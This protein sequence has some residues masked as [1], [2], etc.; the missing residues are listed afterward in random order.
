MTEILVW[1]E[2]INLVRWLLDRALSIR[3]GT[4]L[5]IVFDGNRS[6]Y[7]QAGHIQLWNPGLEPIDIDG[8]LYRVGVRNLTRKTVDDARVS[9]VGLDPQPLDILPLTLHRKDD[10]PQLA[11]QPYQEI[12]SVHP[13]GQEPDVFVDVLLKATSQRAMQIEHIA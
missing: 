3:R 6:P 9:L 12:F 11:G 4:K 5:D 1:L 2:G 7:L 10:N 8:R 13:H